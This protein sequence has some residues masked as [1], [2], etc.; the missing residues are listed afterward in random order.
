MTGSQTDELD[1]ESMTNKEL[2][3]K[4]QQMMGEQVQDVVHRFEEAMEKIDGLE[5][6]FDTKM[7]AKFNELLACLPPPPAA[8][9]QH[10]QQQHHLPD[11]VGRARRVPR[12]QGQQSGAGATVVA[13]AAPATTVDQYDDYDGEYEDEVPPNQ[14]YVQPPAPGRPH[15]YNRNGRA[16]PPPPVRDHDHIPKLKLNIPPFEGRYVPDVYLTWELE[17][18]QRFTCL[19]YPE[20]RRVAAAV[21]AF[22]SFACVWWSEH[23][24]LYHD[25]IPTTWAALKNAMRMLPP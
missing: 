4:F 10:Q 24:R 18:E 6:T 13:S 15:A 7:E 2:H 22:T 14:N 21:C 25:H 20:D 17:T 9:L 16:A 23:C 3:D 8:P 1:W 19:Q 12:A 5:K 11:Q